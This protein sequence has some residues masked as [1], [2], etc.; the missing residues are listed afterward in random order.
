ME[1]N[2]CSRCGSFYVSLN[3]DVCPKCASKESL[4]LSTFKSYIQENEGINSID[5]I[6]TATGIAPKNVNRFLGYENNERSLT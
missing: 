1:A 4:E 2:K 5:T 6:A 3:G